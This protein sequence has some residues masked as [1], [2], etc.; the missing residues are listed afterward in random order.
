[1]GHWE[2]TTKDKKKQSLLKVLG[3]Q[4]QLFIAEAI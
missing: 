1:M 2:E 4:V 3:S